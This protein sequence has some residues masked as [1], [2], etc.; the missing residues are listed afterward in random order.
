MSEVGIFL[1]NGVVGE[2]DFSEVLKVQNDRCFQR[3]ARGESVR[4][5]A[6]VWNF[7]GTPINL[8]TGPL[9]K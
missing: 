6:Q 9:V 4:V 2:V 3:E 8:L 1:R 7:V 5:K